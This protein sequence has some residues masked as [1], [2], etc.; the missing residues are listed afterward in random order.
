M[1]QFNVLPSCSADGSQAVSKGKKAT[2]GAQCK[3]LLAGLM[4]E[5]NVAQ[6]HFVRC[7]KAQRTDG[8]FCESFFLT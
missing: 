7:I 2:V 3:N 8:A 5:M 6:P 1:N 4:A